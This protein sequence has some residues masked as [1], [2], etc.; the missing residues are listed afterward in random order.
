MIVNN[1][2]IL[3]NIFSIVYRIDK[4]IYDILNNIYLEIGD[5]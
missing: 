5:E 2:F 1:M 3:K 4:W